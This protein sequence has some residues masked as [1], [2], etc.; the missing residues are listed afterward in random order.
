MGQIALRW[1][2]EGSRMFIGRDSYGRTVVAGSWPKQQGE[3]GK[4][5]MGL[6]PSDLLVISLCSCS[7]Y[8]VVEILKKQRQNLTGLDITADAKQASEPPYQFTD[9]HLHYVITGPDISAK[10]VEKA[11]EL[12]QNKYCSV[13]ATIRGVTKITYSFEVKGE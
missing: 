13:A 11:I 1:V 12:S 6:K 8:D 9:I 3:Q 5:W 2:G 7:A 4:E 10:K